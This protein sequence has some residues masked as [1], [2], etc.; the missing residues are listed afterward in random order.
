MTRPAAIDAMSRAEQR[1]SRAAAA[2]ERLRTLWDQAHQD[3]ALPSAGVAL[4]AVGGYGRSELSPCSDLDV[5]L[6]AQDGY[7]DEAL[8]A[9][10]EKLWYPL[11]D[12]NVRIDHA[13]RTESD[14]RAAVA[15]DL[16]VA[17]GVL[18]L[19]AVAGDTTLTLGVRSTV[20][21]DWRRSAKRRLPEL[22]ELTRE[23][24]SRVGD[25][26]HATTPDLKE[27]RGGLRDIAT[28][29]AM[30]A[31]WLVDVPS[32][33]LDR[34]GHDLLE[35]RDALQETTGRHTDRL[36]AD[37]AD[38]VATRLGLCDASSLRQL[39]QVTGRGIGHVT[40]VAM[41]NVAWLQPVRVGPRRPVLDVVAPGVGAYRGE[42]VLTEM[43]DPARDP[44]LALR[45]AEAA[46]TR[47][48][49][50]TDAAAARLGHELAPIPAPWPAEAR[51]L[52]GRFLGSGPSLVDVWEALDLYGVVDGLIPEWKRVRHLAPGSSVHRFTVDRHLVQTCVEAA[53]FLDDLDR[54]D[55]LVVAALVHDIGK[56]DV[57]DHSEVGALIAADIVGRMGFRRPDVALVTRLVRHHLLLVEVATGSDLDD[58]GTATAVATAVQDVPT[59]ELLAVLTEADAL[60]TGPQAWSPWRK[61]LVDTLVERTRRHLH[62]QL[63]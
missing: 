42:I 25:L 9:L 14:L 13:V 22:V 34:L 56:G 62:L 31:S 33:E 32:S 15:D 38:E 30:L 41:R 46:A 50:L 2:D 48:L 52:F 45:A 1:R 29:R 37:Y 8:T 60:A 28:L 43:A 11:W 27:A 20:L 44:L 49:V 59:L 24:W 51:G 3:L 18:D 53:P 12:A 55:L 39:L 19:R 5:V 47:D 35:V 17:L 10:A 16:R 21:A 63:A 57:G 36:V 6:L 4:V 61:Q 23:R 40:A 54:P 58:P 26:A 7:D